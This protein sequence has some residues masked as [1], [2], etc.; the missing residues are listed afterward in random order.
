MNCTRSVGDTER[1]FH[2]K[3]RKVKVGLATTVPGVVCDLGGELAVSATA[4]HEGA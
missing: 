1:E 3:D 2:R 4:T